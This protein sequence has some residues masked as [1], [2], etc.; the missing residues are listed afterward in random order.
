MLASKLLSTQF[1]ERYKIWMYGNDRVMS[2][3]TI[4]QKLKTLE[5]F[6]TQCDQKRERKNVSK[7]VTIRGM[8]KLPFSLHFLFQ[9]NT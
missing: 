1:C 9:R 7:F 6:Y 8:K 4:I 5:N 3:V 2:K